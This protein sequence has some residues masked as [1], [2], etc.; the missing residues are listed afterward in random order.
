MLRR[1]QHHFAN[2]RSIKNGLDKARLHHANKISQEASGLLN[3]EQLS[4]IDDIDILSSRV[5][6]V[7]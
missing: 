2:A 5:L 1:D 3:T 4:K 6:R 7:G